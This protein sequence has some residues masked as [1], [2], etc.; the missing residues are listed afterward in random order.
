MY[1][2]NFHLADGKLDTHGHFNG[3]LS[4]YP[5]E[6]EKV[7][8]KDILILMCT[9]SVPSAVCI[10]VGTT[11]VLSVLIDCE[12]RKSEHLKQQHFRRAFNEHVTIDIP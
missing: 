11:L 4:F 8:S 9:Y 6:G 10:D 3:L 5:R 1:E 2:A 7:T 12:I